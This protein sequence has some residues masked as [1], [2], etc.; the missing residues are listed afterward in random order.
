MDCESLIF[1]IDGTLWDST[2][3]VAEGYNLQL[4]REGLEHLCVTADDL[5]RLFG[6]TMTEIADCMFPHMAPE[7]R[8]G[9]MERCM[10]TEQEY[11][12]RDPCRVGFPGVKETLL[13]LKKSHRLFIVSNSQKGYPEIVIQ[14]MGL[15]GVFEGHMCYGDTGLPKGDTIRL[16]MERYGIE[17]A[18]YIGD[19]QTDYEAT[20]KAGVPFVFCSYGFGSPV[21]WSHK[22]EG[23]SDLLTLF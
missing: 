14:K 18:C 8:Y 3:I 12:H 21:G 23:F 13:A 17:D 2:G 20:L 9:L 5:K 19:T 16:L 11:L 1:D 15:E 4:R 22:I 6:K 10:A 7:A